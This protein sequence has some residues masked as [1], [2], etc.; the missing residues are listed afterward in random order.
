MA[1]CH[2]VRK[3]AQ[4]NAICIKVSYASLN[5]L[6]YVKKSWSMTSFRSTSYCFA[7]SISV[8]M[9][10][11]RSRCGDYI[12]QLWFLLLLSSFFLAYSQRS[13]IGC[14]P[15]Y[16][17]CGL[18]ANLECMSEMCCTRL[19]ENRPT[20]CKNYATNHHLR[21]IAQL[22]RAIS[23]QR[24]HVS[25]IGRKLV[26]QHLLHMSSQYGKRQPNFAAF[27]RGHTYI[28]QGGHHV[29]HRPTF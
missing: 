16:T 12:L 8:F 3:I 29:G 13:Q 24:M 6:T 14:L 23:S 28:R 9:A 4:L 1:V 19:A 25:T 17:W 15:F 2:S 5:K 10:A 26:K 22:C 27:S 7:V 11:L 21:N 18:S 20:G